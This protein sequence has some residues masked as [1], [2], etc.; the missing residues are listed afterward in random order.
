MGAAGIQ[1]HLPE[2]AA[3]EELVAAAM[4]AILEVT[5]ELLEPLILV[6]A[7][8]ALGEFSHQQAALIRV[9]LAAPVS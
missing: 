5:T 4:V 7:V 2:M 1:R 9:V 8:V 3:P 6:A